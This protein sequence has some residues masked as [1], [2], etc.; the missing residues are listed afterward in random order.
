M[1]Y[2]AKGN[3]VV[4]DLGQGKV[5]DTTH[6]Q[7][8]LDVEDTLYQERDRIVQV[9][10]PSVQHGTELGS[11]RSPPVHIKTYPLRRRNRSSFLSPCGRNLSLLDRYIRPGSSQVTLAP[12]F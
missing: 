7:P 11:V 12:K 2:Q 5:T 6:V 3:W 1:K 10:K 4:D 9:V 8:L